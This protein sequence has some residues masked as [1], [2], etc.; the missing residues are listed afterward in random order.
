[1]GHVDGAQIFFFLNP[2]YTMQG[3]NLFQFRFTLTKNDTFCLIG[4]MNSGKIVIV[5]ATD[6]I[7]S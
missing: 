3:S 5:I 2:V 6:M 7:V 1:M 4:A